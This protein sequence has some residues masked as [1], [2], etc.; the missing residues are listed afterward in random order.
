VALAQLYVFDSDIK[1][2][3]NR[4][5][6]V[7][8]RE[9]MATLRVLHQVISFVEMFRRAGEYLRNQEV[10]SERLAIHETVGGDL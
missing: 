10:V 9:I 3:V 5:Y 2:Q 4:R 1:V 8:D 6:C 7:T